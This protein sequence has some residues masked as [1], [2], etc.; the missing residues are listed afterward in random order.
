M[1]ELRTYL[2]YNA[3]APMRPEAVE[4]TVAVLSMCGNASSVHREGRAA[5][6]VIEQAREHV[7]ATCGVAGESIVF[8]GSGTE[9]NNL[10]FK[11]LARERRVD[12]LVVCETE[13]PSV[14]QS[15]LDSG[16][17]VQT[18]AVDAAGLADL[19]ALE[20]ILAE[21]SGTP[22]VSIMLANN[23]T[24]VIQP[25][26]RAAEI[27]HRHGALIHTD[28]VQACGKIAV[29][30]RGLDV[31]LLSLSAH[32]VGGP[33]GVG[34]LVVRPGLAVAA[35]MSG[36]GQELK[37]RGGTENV[38]GIAGF[39]AAIAASARDLEQF[40]ALAKL[41]DEIEDA[42]TACDA[43]ATVFSQEVD[44]LPNTTCFAVPDT[45]AELALIALD[46]KGIAVSSGSACSSGKVAR[47][48]VLV[49]MGAGE[50]VVQGAIRVSLGWAS[51]VEDVRR[52][53]NAWRDLAGRR[54]SAAA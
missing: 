48:H 54:T 39:G 13:H 5:R 8:T 29:D 22:L 6:R 3:T 51:K 36:G 52:F 32:K 33:Q 11:G 34:A 30:F 42:V 12:T 25:I 4:R 10:A 43:D 1:T 44:R 2:D 46:L 49:A 47:S 18:V 28:A 7:A 23:E 21:A 40:A 35:Q 27:A 16:V 45:A 20:T 37:R 41:R 9:A 38:A 15:A 31:D 14:L 53:I 24:G 17:P 50:D 19:A 26:R